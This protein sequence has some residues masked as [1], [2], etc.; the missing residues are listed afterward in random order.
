MKR[1]LCLLVF[2]LGCVFSGSVAADEVDSVLVESHEAG[3][4]A[5]VFLLPEP[6]TEREPHYVLT[7]ADSTLP[8]A[9]VGLGACLALARC[10]HNR[11]RSSD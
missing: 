3:V 1:G 6:T 4:V 8:S 11:S 2:M 7:Q 5:I 9:L 10:R